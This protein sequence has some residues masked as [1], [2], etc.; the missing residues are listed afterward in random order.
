MR[1]GDHARLGSQAIPDV[2][3][4]IAC[5]LEIA[6]NEVRSLCKDCM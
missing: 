1:C 6:V 2:V 4:G 3:A 5:E